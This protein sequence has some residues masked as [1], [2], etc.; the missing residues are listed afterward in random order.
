MIDK[1][2]G[3]T[4]IELLVVIAIIALLMSILMPALNRAKSQAKQAVC[5]S[6]LHQWA[7]AFKMFAADN[8]ECFIE[9]WRWM[10]FMHEYIK[11]DDT[12]NSKIYY[13]PAATKTEAQGAPMSTAA[14]ENIA[15]DEDGVE[16]IVRGSYGINQWVT[17]NEGGDRPPE[18]LWRGPNVVG[19]WNVPMFLDCKQYPNICPWF[20]DDPPPYSG[21]E[22][23]GND[24]EMR[25]AC[26]DR[27]TMAVN[28][29]FLDFSVH[30]VRIIKLWDL[31]W[32]R[33]WNPNNAPPPV[34]PD[35]MY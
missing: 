32:H 14:W 9:N 28:I 35:W 33:D 3:F 15:E 6:N 11:S 30:K 1:K 8:K 27:H 10:E 7:I 21:E 4:L 26:I 34:F 22:S 24:D 17:Q 18:L 16:H 13:C 5:Q 31:W 20:T 23:T 2:K 29:A 12:L 19:G 25:R